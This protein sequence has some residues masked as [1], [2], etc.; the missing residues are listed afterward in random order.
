LRSGP[1]EP[2]SRTPLDDARRGVRTGQGIVVTL[3][4]LS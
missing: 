2:D 4:D 1:A 3:E